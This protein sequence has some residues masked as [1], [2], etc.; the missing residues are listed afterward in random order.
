MAL[1]LVALASV[2]A[3]S[4]GQPAVP[5]CEAR[6]SLAW[7]STRD[8]PL[9]SALISLPGATAKL[10]YSRPRARGRIVFGEMVPFGKVWRTGANEPTTLHLPVPAWVAGVPLAAGRYVLLTVPEAERWDVVF[11]TADGTDPARMYQ[12][13]FQVGQGTAAAERIDHHI[14]S[15]T[16]RAEGGPVA[17]ELVLEWERVRVRL[18]VRVLP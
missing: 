11:Y 12:S 3:V 17:S 5:A 4:A 9:D 8:S 1:V 15:L 16:F 7:L 6:G 13:L 14:E 18:P 2:P 10:C